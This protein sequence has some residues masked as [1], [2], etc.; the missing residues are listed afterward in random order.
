MKETLSAEDRNA[1]VEYRQERAKDS[2]KA[3]D[4]LIN[5]GFYVAAVNR[6]YY[7]C[8]YVTIALLLKNNIAAQ[9]HSGVKSMLGLHFVSKGLL[10]VEMGKIYSTLFSKRQS[11]DY[12]DFFYCDAELANEL[13]KQAESYI[14]AAS[15]LLV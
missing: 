2:L 14:D 8:Y 11:G 4:T 5:N 13:K 6:L 7:A 3:A 10:S 1:L 9:T 15:N 12:D